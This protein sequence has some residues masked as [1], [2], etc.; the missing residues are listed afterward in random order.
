MHG[1]NPKADLDEAQKLDQS[2]PSGSRQKN[3]KS[4]YPKNRTTIQRVLMQTL[5][6]VMERSTQ[7]TL[8]NINQIGDHNHQNR[9][10]FET[11]WIAK[12]H[13]RTKNPNRI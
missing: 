11:P 13:Q 7:T 9:I 2:K 6:I 1:Q 4:G 5:T 12:P 10:G 8:W 3:P